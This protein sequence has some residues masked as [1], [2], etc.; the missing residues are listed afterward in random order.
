ML[1]DYLKLPYTRIIREINDESG[2]YWYGKI[3]ELNGCQSDGET[4]EEV[5]KNLDEALIGHLKILLEDGDIIPVPV[6]ET[7]Y[8][9][10]FL[11]R[12]PKTLHYKLAKEAENEGVSLNQYALYKLS[13]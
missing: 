9:G 2:H 13:R 12:L 1:N 4:S 8:S 11:L 10:K 3:L 7:E 6:P 5:L